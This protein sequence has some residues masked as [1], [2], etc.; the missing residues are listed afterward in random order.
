MKTTL[1]TYR[2][3]IEKDGKYYHG[4]VPVLPGC[5]TQGKTVEETRKNLREAIVGYLASLRK[6]GE[7]IP[8]E[9]GLEGVETFDIS[10]LFRMEKS[11][12]YA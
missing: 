1:F 4:Y 11:A 3:F 8:Q 12:S 2:T 9:E 5:H 10:K 6:H 7:P